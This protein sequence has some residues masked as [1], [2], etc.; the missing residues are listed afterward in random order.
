M[1]QYHWD[2]N[3]NQAPRE[4]RGK[5]Q[6]GSTLGIILI[7]VGLYWILKET[8]WS[9]Y[10]PGWDFVRET[11]HSV[12]NFVHV[13][14]GNLLLPILLLVTGLALISGRRK[15]G[16]LLLLIALLIFI[17]GLI[18]PG[19]LMVIFFPVLLIIVGILVLRSIL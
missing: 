4:P 6:G 12:F 8:G 15:V 17:P 10:L 19:V 3:M 11:F 9:V 1:N 5:K 18:I 7:L 14:L 13:H 16:G 2:H